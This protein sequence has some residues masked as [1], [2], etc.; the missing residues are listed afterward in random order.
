MDLSTARWTKASRSS[1]TGDNC[2]EVAL[3]LPE[4]VAVRDSKHPKGHVIVLPAAQWRRFCSKVR[5]DA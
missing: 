1:A 5:V 2:V 4:V 3:N